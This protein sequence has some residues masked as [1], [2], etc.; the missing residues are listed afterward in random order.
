MVPV[1]QDQGRAIMD[2]FVSK[3]PLIIIPMRTVLHFLGLLLITNTI[4]AQFSTS[5]QKIDGV[6]K[7]SL[8]SHDNVIRTIPC[9]FPNFSSIP[10]EDKSPEKQVTSSV[11]EWTLTFSQPGKVFKDI[12]FS[13]PLHGYIVTELGAVYKTVDGGGNWV[14]VMNLGFPYYWYGVHALSPDTVVISGFN[15]QGQINEGIVRWTFDG[16]TTWEPELV[17]PIPVNGVGWLDRVHFFNSDTGIVFNSTSGGCWYT[18]T[19]GKDVSSWT[20]VV[21]NPDQAWLSGNI[22]T[23]DNGLVFGT[24]IHLAKSSNFG[25]EWTSGPCADNVF[26]GGVDFLDDNDLFGWTGGGQISAPVMGW[27][28]RTTDSGGSWGPRLQTFPYPVRAVQFFT[29]STGIALG[30]NLYDEAGG[31]Y[32]SADSGYTWNLDVSTSAEM[33][34]F[35]Y[36]VISADSM[37]IWCVGS[38]GGSTGFVGKLYKARTDNLVTGVHTISNTG[39]PGSWLEQNI[40]NPFTR[41]TTITF[42]IPDACQASLKIFDLCGRELMTLVTGIQAAGRISVEFNANGLVDGVYYYQLRTGNHVETKKLMIQR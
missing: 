32:S 40:P 42:N 18:S 6:A 4:T 26:D 5:Y 24:G 9:S 37:D 3:K 1:W 34:A 20:Y 39:P 14:S 13:D 35:D 27:M 28:H 22:D 23:Q 41:S 8:L 38:T 12:S 25:L 29:G 10:A 16:G 31:I 30:G 33:F 2:I 36:Q 19:G 17:L 21:I 15:N 7:V 11:F